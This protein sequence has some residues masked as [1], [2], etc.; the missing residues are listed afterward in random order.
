MATSNGVEVTITFLEVT[1]RPARSSVP[2]RRADISGIFRADPPSLGFY[3]FLYNSVGDTCYWYMRRLM[4]DEDLRNVIEDPKVEVYVLY[5]RG[6]PAGYVELD[7]RIETDV[8]IAYL[9]LLP[10]FIG[11]GLGSWL[12]AWAI[13][14]AWQGEVSRVW[15]HTCTLDHPSALPMYQRGG[16][17]AFKQEREWVEFETLAAAGFDPSAFQSTIG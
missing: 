9:G 5:V 14:C 4:K 13:S 3:R 16:L 8:E 15:L 6:T 7:R 10:E 17:C 12:L 2:P 1:Q 11:R